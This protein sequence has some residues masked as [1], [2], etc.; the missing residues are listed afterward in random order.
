MIY[1]LYYLLVG[2]D[3]SSNKK[4]IVL[5]DREG[6]L[7]SRD[8]WQSSELVESRKY[9]I[10]GYKFDQDNNIAFLSDTLLNH[11]LM[12][13]GIE[14][15]IQTWSTT[16]LGFSSY[17][18]ISNNSSM[19]GICDPFIPSYPALEEFLLYSLKPMMRYLYRFQKASGINVSMK[20]V[21]NAMNHEVL[22]SS[23]DHR[24]DGSDF[25]PSRYTVDCA[26]LSIKVPGMGY[27]RLISISD[28]Y[29]LTYEEI[30]TMEISVSKIVRK[31]SSSSRFECIR[32][33]RL[34]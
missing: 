26:N 3:L 31:V 15:R 21:V 1:T 6:S 33:L 32:F 14:G 20:F 9:D 28:V 13:K 17:N 19:K 10:A 34:W 12:S 16:D 27:H 30:E 29:D 18:Y 23:G 4:N 25:R 2:Q 24:L 11:S 8:I 22:I 7:V 5:M